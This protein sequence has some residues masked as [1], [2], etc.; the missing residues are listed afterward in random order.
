[1]KTQTTYDGYSPTTQQEIH[2]MK[3]DLNSWLEDYMDDCKDYWDETSDEDELPN[4]KVRV[5]WALEPDYFKYTFGYDK[6]YMNW[7]N[8]NYEYSLE[9][10]IYMAMMNMGYYEKILHPND[11]K[12]AVKVA[13][14]YPDTIYG[15]NTW[16][17]EKSDIY[18]EYAQEVDETINEILYGAVQFVGEKLCSEYGLGAVKN[19]ENLECQEEDEA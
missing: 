10:M 18:N 13:T 7:V 19:F 5:D 8:G 3:E 14:D 1:M 11:Y 9:N 6:Y 17:E 12:K 4:F 16:D 15:I 2:D